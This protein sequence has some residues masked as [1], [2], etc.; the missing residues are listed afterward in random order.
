MNFYSLFRPAQ[1]VPDE[2]RSNF[3]HL[4][5]D[6]AWYGLLAAS[7]M[8]FVTVYAA[9]Q[10]ANALQIGLFSA[11]PAAVNLLF[12]LPAGR[13][14]E[15]RSVDRA[16]S[17]AA[18]VSR[19]FYLLWVPLPMLL[20]AQTQ[21][22]TLIGLTL[23]MSI[24]GTALAVGFNALFADAV[25]PEWRGF[26]V[27]IRNALLSM[28]FIATSLLSGRILD[29]LPFPT[30]YQVVFAIGFVG[31]TISTYHLW[32]IKPYP[33]ASERPHA[34]KALGDLA[35]PGVLRI[36][37][38]SLRHGAGLRFL[39]RRRGLRLLE[40]DA[41]KGPYG[42]LVAVLF[43]FHLALN[44]A[45]P[46]FPLHWVNNLHLNDQQIGLGTAIFY[47]SVFF[48]ST[49]L[50]WLTRQWSNQRITAVGAMLMS[51][52]P[53]LMALSHGLGLFLVASAAGGL[54]WS[55][56]GGALTNFI[57]EKIP[58]DRRPPYLAWYNLA[59]NAAILLGSL[60]GPFLGGVMGLRS[61]LLAFAGLRL[62]TALLI[63][64]WE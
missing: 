37:A 40:V 3:R 51:S 24:P 8:S 19:F 55:L 58:Q 61:A 5:L 10:G 43:S 60:V 9:R 7:A 59:L 11:G 36:L 34:G 45:I 28:I 38:D 1:P 49:Q 41:L 33:S 16:V 4:Y 13:W 47:V 20:G 50:A 62:L 29:A 32:R 27:G 12:T 63:L 22:W 17:W 64:R 26:V 18:A 44:L 2:C 25:R 23:L 54:G 42:R 48:G 53:S 30:G 52:Y 57:L 46:L 6:I 31:G 56:A 15:K 39:I 14:L 35:R 21:I